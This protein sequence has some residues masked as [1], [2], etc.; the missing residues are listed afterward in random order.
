MY[1]ARIQGRGKKMDERNLLYVETSKLEKNNIINQKILQEWGVQTAHDVASARLLLNNHNYGVGIVR[2]SGNGEELLT[3]ELKEILFSNPYIKWIALLPQTAL[4]NQCMCRLIADHFY[5]FH[6]LPIDEQRLNIVLGRAFGNGRLTYE[7]TQ[8]QLTEHLD[9]DVDVDEGMVGESPAINA[10]HNQIEKVAKV[11]TP[12]LITGESGTGKELA[13]NLIHRS[14]I[15]AGAPFVAVNCAALPANLIQAELF[16]YERGAFTGAYKQKIGRIESANMGTI[17]L[18]EIGDLPAD[19]QITLLR[20]L[21]ERTID[22]VGG[23]EPVAVDVRVIAATHVDLQD[24]VERG[25]FREDLYYRLR[26]LHLHMPTLSE[27][28]KDVVILANHFFEQFR[29]EKRYAVKDFSHSAIQA[30]YSHCWPGN[31]RELINSVRRAL[32]M[33]DGPLIL[34][35]DLGLERRGNKRFVMSLEESRAAADLAAIMQAFENGGN[36]ITRAAELLGISRGTLYRLMEKH[37][38]R[39]PVRMPDHGKELQN[40]QQ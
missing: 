35:A 34:P 16:G 20:F 4:Q 26:V 27:R 38:I 7:T 12:V 13:A 14:S 30:M 19:M 32:V 22:R 18:D 2:F 9:V 17:F 37:D 25:E 15:R 11:D 3:G 31:V 10:L 28:G 33:S 5:D 36:N 40:S 8:Q 21:E 23:G 39:W 6:H 1:L 29:Y 24:A